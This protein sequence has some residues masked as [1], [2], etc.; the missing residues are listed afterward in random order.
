MQVLRTVCQV[1]KRQ[2]TEWRIDSIIDQQLKEFAS[3]NEL[4]LRSIV[5]CVV[6]CGKQGI[7]F[8]GHR[9]DTTA[10]ESANRGNFISLVKFRAQTDDILRNF[11]EHAPK[12]G[13]YAS[14]KVQNDLIDICGDYVRECTSAPVLK[15]N[16]FFSIIADEVTDSSNNHSVLGVPRCF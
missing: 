10:T 1:T 4:A 9:D 6:Y 3:L 13:T 15:N 2:V 11:I 5:E 12:N 14:K 8:R 7:S 16:S